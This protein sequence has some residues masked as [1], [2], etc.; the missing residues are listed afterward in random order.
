MN[1]S[2]KQKELLKHTLGADERYMKKQW[3]YRNYFCAGDNKESKDR[4]ELEKMEEMGL[5]KSGERLGHKTFWATKA[6]ALAI[7]FKPYQL[8]KTDLAA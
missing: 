4:L 6:G 3:G 5:V 8:R 1:I 2:E 7:G